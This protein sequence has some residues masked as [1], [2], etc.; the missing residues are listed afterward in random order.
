MSHVKHFEEVGEVVYKNLKDLDKEMYVWKQILN[1]RSKWTKVELNDALKS[2][3]RL[4]VKKY[5]LE[6]IKIK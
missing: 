1:N 4:R 5:D 3:N 2:I 6:P